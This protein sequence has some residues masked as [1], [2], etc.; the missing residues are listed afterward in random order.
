[1]FPVT[2]GEGRR[3]RLTG[4]RAGPDDAREDYIHHSAGR[5]LDAWLQLQSGLEG[6]GTVPCR[7]AD[8][9]AWWPDK[10]DLD[11][12]TTRGAI[13][14]CCRCPL[15]H[16]C[17]EYAIAADERFGVWGATLPEERRTARLVAASTF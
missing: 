6:I 5:H 3:R 7:S 17:A 4:G 10:R 1:V 14:A 8:A 12:S 15:R 11:S 16:P 9:S 13:A 2:P